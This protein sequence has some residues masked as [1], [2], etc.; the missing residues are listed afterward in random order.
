MNVRRDCI[1]HYHIKPEN[2]LLNGE[3]CPKVADFGMVKLMGREISKVLTTMRGTFG[4]LAP[5]WISGLPITPKVDVYSFGMMLF[6]I[7]S[8][9]RNSAQSVNENSS[10]FPI[11]AATKI[12]QG[13]FESLLDERLAGTASLEELERACKVA[14]W[15]IQDEEAQR[16]TM[17]Q[18]VLMLEGKME[19]YVPP[20]PNYLQNLVNM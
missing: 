18:V 5:E 13:D 7:I 12:S 1:I 15:C 16:P 11:L 9:R 8:G 14:C 10:F 20:I 4:Y 17:G 3:F 6:E 19:V 2:V